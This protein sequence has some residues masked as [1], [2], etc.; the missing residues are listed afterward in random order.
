M[1]LFSTYNVSAR[2][3]IYWLSLKIVFLKV[4]CKRD[5]CT[6]KTN[7]LVL[8]C[9]IKGISKWG[10]SIKE[11][12]FTRIYISG[13][14]NR[15]DY[16][17][18]LYIRWW[19]IEIGLLLWGRLRLFE[20]IFLRYC[21]ILKILLRFPNTFIQ[22]DKGVIIGRSVLSVKRVRS[23]AL[24]TQKQPCE[25]NRNIKD[26]QNNITLSLPSSPDITCL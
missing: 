25:Y 19:S 22:L 5:E 21:S 4:F 9:W 15:L 7:L 6:I 24:A 2:Q 13:K 17:F 14:N 26:T 8:K 18:W 11:G 23:E 12:F 3:I 10:I 20:H 16:C 1:I